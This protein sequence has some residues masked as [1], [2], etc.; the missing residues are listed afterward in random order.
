MKWTTKANKY[1]KI[2][3]IDKLK[4]E[5][6]DIINEI[7]Y[8]NDVIGLLPTGYGKSLC[9]ILPPLLTKKIMIVISPLIALMEDQKKNLENKNIIC[10]VLNSFNENIK[11]DIKLIKNNEIKII[12]MSPEYFINSSGMDLLNELYERNKI[13]FITIDEAHCIN[14]WG[15]D[16]R[17]EYR[18]LNILKKLYPTIPIICLTATAND[19][20]C[21][22]IISILNL[23]EPK[24]IKA[25]FDRP[26]IYINID[27]LPT[28]DKRTIS[29]D[30]KFNTIR[31]YLDKYKND[32]I[33][34]Y[35]NSRND[36]E[37]L[38]DKLNLFDYKSDYYHAGLSN[39]IKKN[40]QD[41]FI[42]NKINIIISTI[43]FG[44]GIDQIVKCVIII[45]CP[46]S[47]DDYYQ[48]IGRAGRDNKKCE[49]IFYFDYTNYIINYKTVENNKIKLDNILKVKELVNT[50]TCKR[51]Y[52]LDYLNDKSKYFTNCYNCSSCNN[53]EL[54]DITELIWDLVFSNDSYQKIIKNINDLFLKK[55]IINGNYIETNLYNIIPKWKQYIINNDLNID[56][57]EDNQKIKVQSRFIID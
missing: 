2:F 42:N 40:V 50:N 21:N 48:Q 53:Y 41:N 47:I 7:L 19:I 30:H 56:K 37:K 28:K 26:N 29:I 8:G 27:N 38:S 31:K 22:E 25:P 45:G 15:N 39:N 55:L 57:L 52:I 44:M 10:S 18:D 51:R 43:A 34:I 54:V 9:Y 49:S 14:S 13:G 1:L 5:Q 32:K 11:N 24:I 6:I 4:N 20:I 3:N 46:S 35:V 16:F 33:I 12:Y 36:T 23:N 17:P